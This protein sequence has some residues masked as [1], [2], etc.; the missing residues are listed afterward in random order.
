MSQ[1]THRQVLRTAWV[2]LLGWIL[3]PALMAQGETITLQGTVTNERGAALPGATV[4]PLE[5]QRAAVVTDND[6]SYTLELRQGTAWTLRFGFVGYKAQERTVPATV[7]GTQRIDVRLAAG[8]ALDA[9]E[10]VAD[11]ERTKPVQRINPKVAARIPSPAAPLKTCSSKPQSI[12]TANC[13]A[14]TTCGAEVLTRTW[15]T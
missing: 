14:V 11:G 3:A 8:V 2:L 9:S 13:P 6:G 5:Q 4:I 12:S 10:V 1:L 15:S 7:T